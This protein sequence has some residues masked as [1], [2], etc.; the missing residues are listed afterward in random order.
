MLPTALQN[1][2]LVKWNTTTVHTLQYTAGKVDT[3]WMADSQG[4]VPVSQDLLWSESRIISKRID[5]STQGSPPE[6]KWKSDYFPWC[7][8]AAVK[9]APLH[10]LK[11]SRQ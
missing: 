11:V 7:T 6:K 2:L 1:R 10:N 3:F 8:T 9:T 5:T 4:S